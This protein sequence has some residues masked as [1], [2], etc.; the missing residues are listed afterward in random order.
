[1]SVSTLSLL[2]VALCVRFVAVRDAGTRRA[3]QQQQENGNAATEVAALQA[4]HKELTRLTG[5]HEG[6][7]VKSNFYLER[8]AGLYKKIIDYNFLCLCVKCTWRNCCAIQKN[9]DYFFLCLFVKF[10][11]SGVLFRR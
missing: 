7:R 8:T 3:W 10:T 9:R 6:G 2:P 4:M 5:E 1:M 11:W